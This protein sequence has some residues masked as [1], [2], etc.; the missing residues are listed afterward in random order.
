M[1]GRLRHVA[2]GRDEYPAVGDWV[3]ARP[4]PGE[5][6]A[7]IQHL[8]P[9]RTKLS[10]KTAGERTDE[11][12]MAANLDTVFVVASLNQ[13]M[14]VRR[15]ERY[16]AVAWDSG[17]APVVILNRADLAEDASARD[18]PNSLSRGST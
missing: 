14:N 7:V 18:Q 2:A 4:L 16:L 6:R 1:T 12:V 3:L 5:A 10:R 8:L 15:I 17:A 9:R 11:Q 13:E